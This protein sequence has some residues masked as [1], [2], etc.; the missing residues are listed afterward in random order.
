MTKVAIFGAGQ[1]GRAV[2]QIISTLKYTNG[3]NPLFGIEAFV[4]DSNQDNIEKLG[5]GTNVV[6]DVSA[7]TIDNISVMLL[8][9]AATHVINAMPFTFNTKYL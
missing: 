4:I 3:P 9:N 6:V 7:F 1:I 5:H 2:F 8:E